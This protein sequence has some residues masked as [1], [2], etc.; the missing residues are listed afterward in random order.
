VYGPKRPLE[1]ARTRSPD[2]AEDPPVAV[3]SSRYS[4]A[5]DCVEE[6]ARA[7]EN[8]G[9]IDSPGRPERIVAT[10]ET[11]RTL[12]RAME[13]AAWPTS[14]AP[15]ARSWSTSWRIWLTSRA[16]P[17]AVLSSRVSPAA[18]MRMPVRTWATAAMTVLT[19]SVARARL[20]VSLMRY[21]PSTSGVKL[22]LWIESLENA[23]ELPSGRSS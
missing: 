13:A 20:T 22:G 1:R 5:T 19:F 8:A 7:L 11:Y 3:L 23:A 21:V 12:P 17:R 6:L 16:Q 15:S 14:M 10:P 9:T 2:D 18:G 4:E